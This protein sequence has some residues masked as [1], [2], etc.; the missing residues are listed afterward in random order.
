MNIRSKD[1]RSR[2][3]GQK[4]QKGDRVASV[5]YALYR[6]TLAALAV[7]SNKKYRPSPDEVGPVSHADLR[8][9]AVE[10]RVSGAN[11]RLNA[12]IDGST[13]HQPEVI[14]VHHTTAVAV[15]QPG[16]TVTQGCYA[17]VEAVDKSRRRW[18]DR[19]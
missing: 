3:Q 19:V 15:H 16:T 17:V 11:E 2:S 10:S 7:L 13:E 18:S 8:N 6:V 9:C 1:Q 12:I 4:V 5:S 14:S